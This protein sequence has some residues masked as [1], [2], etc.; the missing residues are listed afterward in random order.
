MPPPLSPTRA[1][2]AAAPRGRAVVLAA[3][4]VLGATAGCTSPRSTP[5]AAASSSAS[6]SGST[7][8][9]AASAGDRPS[10][11]SAAPDPAA[12]GA[13]EGSS[14][15]AP[16]SEILPSAAPG[17]SGLSV[18]PPPGPSLTGPLP[19]T[20]NANGAVVKGFP[21][22]VVPVPESITVVSSSV[23]ASGDRLQVG[24]QASSDAAPADVQAAYVAA[25]GGAG[26]AVSDSPSLPGT[27]ATAF[28]RG[29]DGLVLTTSDRIGGG[30]ELSIAGTLTTA[31]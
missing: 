6:S 1:P 18:P 23:S 9:G 26:F 25:L 7:R 29:P 22:T 4:L 11:G 2:A 21:T 16:A 27:T 8:D 30:T 31:G 14:E 20:G 5:D 3:V 28:T 24:L 13:S 10:D 15:K 19:A 12:T 17:P